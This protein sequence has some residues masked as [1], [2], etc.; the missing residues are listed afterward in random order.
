MDL[1]TYAVYRK[2]TANSTL[3]EHLVKNEPVPVDVLENDIQDLIVPLHNTQAEQ[4]VTNYPQYLQEHVQ[5]GTIKNGDNQFLINGEIAEPVIQSIELLHTIDRKDVVSN[6]IT[7]TM[8]DLNGNREVKIEN[9]SLSEAADNFLELT[10]MPLFSDT[11]ET[12]LTTDTTEIPT[13]SHVILSENVDVTEPTDTTETVEEAEALGN[14]PSFIDDVPDFTTDSVFETDAS[15]IVEPVNT[16]LEAFTDLSFMN[17]ELPPSNVKLEPPMFEPAD[18]ALDEDIDTAFTDDL[19]AD[20]EDTDAV[21]TDNEDADTV[22]TDNEDA[23]AVLTDTEDTD[24]VLTD[25]EDADNVLT[26]IEDADNVLTDTESTDNED[27]D[28]VL[29]DNEPTD[30]E[31]ADKVLTD[32]VSTDNESTDAGDKPL[33]GYSFKK[34]YD[35]LVAE[36]KRIGLD[37]RL[38]NLHLS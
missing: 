2:L 15:E 12:F 19:F 18:D 14:A 24:A 8:M 31:D 36:I 3:L 25:I 32:N 1:K 37:K 4:L 35:Y 17:D 21:F 11:Q 28:K 23:D 9:L 34:A 26:D 38:P 13:D 20:T 33:D 30:N 7:K 29:T 22:F 27:A 16:D 5:L 6:F 10:K